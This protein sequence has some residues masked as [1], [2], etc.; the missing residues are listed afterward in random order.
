MNAG[1]TTVHHIQNGQVDF[2]S[3]HG[4]ARAVDL[5]GQ[6]KHKGEGVNLFAIAPI[7]RVYFERFRKT[8]QGWRIADFRETLTHTVISSSARAAALSPPTRVRPG[9]PR[10]NASGHLER[11]VAAEEIAN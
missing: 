11:L 1:I 10:E 6:I 2:T 9:T 4:G 7:G 3:G 8:P 5:I